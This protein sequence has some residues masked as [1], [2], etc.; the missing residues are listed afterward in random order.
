MSMMRLDFL[1]S[2]SLSCSITEARYILLVIDYFS[3]FVFAKS[4]V[5]CTITSVA[6]LL[7]NHIVSI[8]RYSRS[9]Y[10]NNESHF[11]SDEIEALLA[12]H[13]VTHFI[14]LVTYSSSV[15]LIERMMQLMIS[16]LRAHCIANEDSNV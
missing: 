6:D 13:D 15:D 14:A 16:E 4:Y 12:K 2:I 11:T 8:M 7:A 1:S 9:I 10:S 5:H 3:R